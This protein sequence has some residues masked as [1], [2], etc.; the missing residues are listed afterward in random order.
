[1]SKKP[2]NSRVP[3][4]PPLSEMSKILLAA[5]QA[6]PNRL[7]YHTGILGRA[8][9]AT[10]VAHLDAAYAELLERGLIEPSDGLVSF[11]GEPKRLF[12]LTRRGQSAVQG[13]AA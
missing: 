13:H 8:Y 12:R 6:S 4:S 11:F 1:M 3:K 5:M 7:E 10:A 2:A 9:S